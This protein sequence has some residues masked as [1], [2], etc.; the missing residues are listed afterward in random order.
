MAKKSIPPASKKNKEDLRI[1]DLKGYEKNP[2]K[3]KDGHHAML[4]KSMQEFGDLSGI[5]FNLKTKRLVGG[6][7]RQIAFND[8]LPVTIAR[9][10]DNP[11]DKGTVREGFVEFEGERFAYREVN[12]DEKKEIA[13]NI[14][15]NK[16]AGSFDFA[17]LQDH[18]TYLDGVNFDMDLTMHD[19]DEVESICAG[20]KS[21]IDSINN[22]EANLDGID[23]KIVITCPQDLKDEVLIY[24]KAKLLE[25]SF[26]GV[27]IK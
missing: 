26:E 17:L 13:A 15:A 12:W 7:Q 21:D 16:G 10:Y 4:L 22:T 8:N 18:L 9:A 23:G 3:V 19:K 6:H 25:T 5:V 27:H 14:A 1:K 20:W 24:L 2:R 11:T